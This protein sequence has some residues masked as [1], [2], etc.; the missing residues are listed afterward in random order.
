MLECVI[1]VSEGRDTSLIHEI[2]AAAGASLLDLHRDPDHHRS[3]LTMAGPEVEEAARRVVRAAVERIDLRRHHGAHPRM[4][5]ADVVPFTPLEGSSLEDALL[6][7]DGLAGWASDELMLPCFLFGP[8]RSLPDVR[9]QAFTTLAPDRGPA[10]PH[11]RAGASAVGARGQLV[12]YNLWLGAG[13]STDLAKQVAAAIRQPGIRALG[14][15][16][17]GRAQVSCNLVEP[18]V[19][20][21]DAVF[22]AV[23]QRVE[24]ERAELVGLVPARVLDAIRPSRWEMLDLHPSKTIEAR[25]EQAGLDVAGRGGR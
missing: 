8:D 14:L 13:C 21:P 6:A 4:G 2:G 7:R 24:I 5:A 15:A 23:A 22:D 11:P 16:V 3:V 10:R 20:G 9:R 25:L 18:F 1:N 19:S 17:G 12:A